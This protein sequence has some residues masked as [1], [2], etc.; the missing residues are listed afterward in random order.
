MES[1]C[2]VC[3]FL[4]MGCLSVAGLYTSPHLVAVRERIRVNGKPLSEEVFAKYFFEV[5]DRLDKNTTVRDHES[6]HRELSNDLASRG[7]MN[8]RQKNLAISVS[9]HSSLSMLSW[10]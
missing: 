10:T 5:W 4:G 1:R 6:V 8:L 7:N 9:S 2:V 3:D